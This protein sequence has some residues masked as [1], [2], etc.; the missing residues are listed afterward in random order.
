MRFLFYDDQ[1]INVLLRDEK[2]SGGAAVQA[3]GWLQG[4]LSQG[5]EVS[6]MTDL[7]RKGPLKEECKDIQLYP[8]FDPHKGI[9]WIRWLY[10]RVPYLY[11]HIKTINP[12]Y[13]YIGIPSW[14]SFLFAIICARL[15]VK[16]IQRISNDFLLDDRI[17]KI[18]S[19]THR[20]F[21]RLGIR[22]AHCV[23]CQNDYQLGIIQREFPGK[24]VLKISNPFFLP[25]ERAGMQQET[26][27]YI[28]WMGIFQ[29]QKNLK[30]LHELA[31][32]LPSEQFYVAGKESAYIDRESLFYLEALKEL[33][34][35]K[36]VGFLSRKQVIPFLA[37]A[38]FLLNT[39]HYEGFSN[40]FLEA[41]AAGTPIISSDKVNPDSIISANRL[42]II[43]SGPEDLKAKFASLSQESRDEM[44]RNCLKYVAEH[45][46]YQKLTRDLLQFL[47]VDSQIHEYAT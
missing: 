33:P 41:M 1:A 2:P 37:R 28:A 13:F 46:D 35:V 21:Q 31:S 30:L 14:H 47:E 25:M 15:K 19:P 24:K 5:H 3:H 11:K 27:D 22:W 4:L 7:Q 39:S 29:Y 45:H 36:L 10:Y 32:V 23:L 9:R 8:L 16:F 42:G 12:D 6:L 18:Y 43:Y 38:K 44:S 26:K 34:N 20:F 40:T 17:Y